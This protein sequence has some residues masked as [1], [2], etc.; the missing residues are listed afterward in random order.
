MLVNYQRTLDA[1]VR[2]EGCE[3]LN[4]VA[5]TDLPSMK[6]PFRVLYFSFV[7]IVHKQFSIQYDHI[8]L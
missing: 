2:Y 7:I 3:R 1:V 4:S 6:F 8:C 5:R